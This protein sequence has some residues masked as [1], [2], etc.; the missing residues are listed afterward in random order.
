MIRLIVVCVA[1]IPSTAWYGA[2]VLWAA[3]RGVPRENPVYDVAPRTWSKMILTLSGAEVV[4]EGVEIIDDSRPQILVA[5]HT[6]WYDVLAL[7]AFMPGR[8]VF[9]AKKE[10]RKVPVFGPGA[11]ACGHIFIDRQDRSSAVESLGAARKRLEEDRPTV[12]MFP[13]GTRSR[14]GTLKPFKKGAFVLAIQAGVDIVPVAITG[15][16]NIMR[17]GSWKVSPGLIRVRFGEP[18]PVS[19]MAVEDRNELTGQAWRAVAE[20]LSRDDPVALADEAASGRTD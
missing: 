3:F 16:R 17:K 6:S 19:G 18:I 14:D 9:V 13:E 7:T 15:S 4:Y 5:N 1:L 8:T 2:K 12:I 20:L 10:L 11:E